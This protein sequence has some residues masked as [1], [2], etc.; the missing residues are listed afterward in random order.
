MDFCWNSFNKASQK[1]HH[2]GIIPFGR[3]DQS[4]ELPPLRVDQDRRRQ[5]NGAQ[6]GHRKHGLVD[7]H[8]EIGDTDLVVET[9][10]D[11]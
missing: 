11:L 5:A 3:A 10:N 9:P 7:I 8:I 1:G 2:L 6:R 4:P